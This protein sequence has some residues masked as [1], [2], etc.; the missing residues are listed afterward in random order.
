MKELY[1]IL[2]L[3]L[4]PLIVQNTPIDL[5]NVPVLFIGD[6]HTSN[7][8]WGW[9]VILKNKTKLKLHNTSIVGKHLPYMVSVAKKTITPYFK[10]CFVYGGVNDLYGKRDPY[11]VFKDVQK[12]VNICKQN[13]VQC[14][15]ITGVSPNC[16]K[17][18]KDGK[19]FFKN[20]SK[21]QQ[22]LT[23]SIV[24]AKVISITT[25][26]TNDCYDWV[27]HMNQSGHKKIANTVIEKMNF[28][29]Y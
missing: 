7:H 19:L 15:I 5:N 24:G 29:I 10:Y 6:S 28:K 16:I 3:I 2:I 12:I 22:L 25:V 27:C 4:S 13:N 20:Y 9:Q 26:N 17:P 8:S 11:L 14:V 21:Y 1:L 23:D 18:L